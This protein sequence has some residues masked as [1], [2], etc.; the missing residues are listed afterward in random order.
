MKKI[1]I[2]VVVLGLFLGLVPKTLTS[3]CIIL[4]GVMIAVLPK[5]FPGLYVNI[6]NYL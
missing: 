2:I 6:Y 1:A 4:F 3:F 5:L